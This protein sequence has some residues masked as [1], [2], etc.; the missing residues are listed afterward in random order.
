[1]KMKMKKLISTRMFLSLIKKVLF[2]LPLLPSRWIGPKQTISPL[3]ND[4]KQNLLA[5]VNK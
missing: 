3:H 1:M 2:L 5:Q 4:P